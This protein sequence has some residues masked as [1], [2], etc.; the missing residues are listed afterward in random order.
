MKFRI[1]DSRAKEKFKAAGVDLA[2]H[3]L[4]INGYTMHYVKTGNDTMPTLF[5]FHG[6]P[7]SWNA[8]ERYL[9]DKEL[10]AHYRMVSIDRPGFGYSEFGDARPLAVQSELIKPVLDSINNNKPLF[11][12]GHSLGG[13]MAIKL[14]ADYPRTFTGMVLLAPSVDPSEE[15]PERWRPWLIKTPLEYLVPGA[16]APSNRELWYLKKDLKNLEADF[17]KIHC[18]VWIVHGDKDK[19]VPIGNSDYAGKMLVNSPLVEVTIIKGANHFIPWMHYS[20]IKSILVNLMDN[21]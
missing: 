1:S 16:M 14:E 3:R 18:P 6:S 21:H 20:E 13:P 9:S 17:S 12:I 2:A 19:L 8:F 11:V 7:G 4:R 5:F 10:L 15:K